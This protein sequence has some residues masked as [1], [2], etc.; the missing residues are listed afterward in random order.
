MLSQNG[1]LYLITSREE[2]LSYIFLCWWTELI[3]QI[4]SKGTVPCMTTEQLYVYY[5][6]YY[7]N[8]IYWILDKHGFTEEKELTEVIKFHYMLKQN[9]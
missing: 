8:S 7:W 3:I 9:K 4:L 2:L 1:I 6:G 5:Q